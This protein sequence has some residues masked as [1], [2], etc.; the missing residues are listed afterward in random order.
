MEVISKIMLLPGT[1]E[2]RNFFKFHIAY[3]TVLDFYRSLVN[4]VEM[5]QGMYLQ[6]MRCR[7]NT[8]LFP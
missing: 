2:V 4:V 3:G 6:C 5:R 8:I 7:E 1:N